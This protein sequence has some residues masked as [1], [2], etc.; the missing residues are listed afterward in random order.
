MSH[1]PL[2]LYVSTK[3][4]VRNPTAK[5]P[6]CQTKRNL[7][8]TNVANLYCC[9]P[10]ERQTNSNLQFAILLSNGLPN[11][12]ENN[13]DSASTHIE[14]SKNATDHG[15]TKSMCV[16]LCGTAFIRTNTTSSKKYQNGLLSHLARLG[17][18]GT[19]GPHTC[20]ATY[21]KC[22]HSFTYL[23]FCDLSPPNNWRIRWR[24]SIVSAAGLV[25][26][27]GHKTNRISSKSL[28]ITVVDTVDYSIDVLCAPV[29]HKCVNFKREVHWRLNWKLPASALPTNCTLFS[30]YDRVISSD[31]YTCF[32]FRRQFWLARLASELSECVQC[33]LDESE[34]FARK[35]YFIFH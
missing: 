17:G 29:S 27:I 13:L 14:L 16:Q 20:M 9:V 19:K 34:Q 4:T 30:V 15:R 33:R 1:Y 32:F 2:V 11:A 35:L 23:R 31:G 21:N 7:R 10:T 26:P 3:N 8:Q 6:T 5:H 18:Y 22:F 25:G 28:W 12:K 24:K